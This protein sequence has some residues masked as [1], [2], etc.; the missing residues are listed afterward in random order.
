MEA[1]KERIL[2][3][4]KELDEKIDKLSIY[5]NSG[6]KGLSRL[7]FVQLEIMKAYTQVLEIRLHDSSN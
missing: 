4:Q 6:A 7:H 3:E 2:E 1:Y 5:I